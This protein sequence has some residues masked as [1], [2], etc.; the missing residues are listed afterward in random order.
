LPSSEHIPSWPFIYSSSFDHALL[1]PHFLSIISLIMPL[2]VPSIAQHHL[3][4]HVSAPPK[5]NQI[6]PGRL[7]MTPKLTKMTA[8]LVILEIMIRWKR[9][10]EMKTRFTLTLKLSKMP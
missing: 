6:I 7:K 10:R 1:I 4:D 8:G 3:S 9:T 5:S 2:P